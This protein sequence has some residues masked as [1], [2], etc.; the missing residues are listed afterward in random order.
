MATTR[1]PRHGSL[2]FWPRKRARRQHSRIRHHPELKEP[3]LTGFAG[4]KVGMTHAIAID[5]RPASHTKG[6]EIFMPL[7]VIECPPMSVA[8]IRLYKTTPY[9]LKLAA[10]HTAKSD[11]AKLAEYEK[12]LDKYSDVRVNVET[13]PEMT[14]TGKKKPELFEMAIGGDIQSQM[15]YAKQALGKEVKLQ[16]VFREGQQVDVYAVTKGKG[17]QG[18]VKRFGVSLRPHKSEKGR[19]GPGNLG[20][21]TGNRSWTVA[22]AGKMG[23]H[24]RMERNKWIIKISDSAKGI[25]VKGG[26][27]NYGVVKNPYMLL[28]G[29][30][31]GSR[32]RLVKLMHAAR[33]NKLV[34]EHAPQT[35]YMSLQSK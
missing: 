32:K 1:N 33:R 13:K 4:Y 29:S 8:S 10:E 21:W 27:L 3:K 35:T 11:H 23:Y 6:N 34:P 18:P 17:F 31:Q 12:E 7:T 15:A 25:G 26:F 20:P 28:K 22:H 2:Q 19:R 16:D 30:V 9:G 24:N 14:G 5:N